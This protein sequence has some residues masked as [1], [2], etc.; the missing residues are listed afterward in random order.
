VKRHVAPGGR[1]VFDVF[2]PNF[3]LMTTD[4]SAESEDTPERPLPDGRF[5]RRTA[6]VLR[7]RWVDQVS[8]IELIY[9]VRTGA[10]VTRL[11]QAFEMRWYTATEL[12]HLLARTGFRVEAMYGDF[13]R[14]T[15]HDDSPEIVVVAGKE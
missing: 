3:A 5:F 11:V 1:F 15:L 2:N 9:Y 8:E 10:Q 12:E 7:V 6:R 13:A 4:R 14:G